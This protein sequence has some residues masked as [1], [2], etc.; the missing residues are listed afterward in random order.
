M[1]KIET[2]N[3]IRIDKRQARKIYENNGELYM[4][5]HK[6]NP[7]NSWGL[8]LG[9]VNTFYPFDGMVNGATFYN[10][11]NETGNY[12]AFYIKKEDAAV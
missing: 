4:I 10:C 11:N 2:K 8:L 7:E 12:L 9:P 3:Y 5:P 6:M 1:Q